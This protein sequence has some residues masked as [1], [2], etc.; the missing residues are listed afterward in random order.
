MKKILEKFYKGNE[1]TSYEELYDRYCIK[2]KYFDTSSFFTTLLE[3]RKKEE[4]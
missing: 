3:F 4:I 1:T 2:I